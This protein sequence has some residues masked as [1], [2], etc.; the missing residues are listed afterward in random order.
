MA[1]SK[2]R[3]GVKWENVCLGI[4]KISKKIKKSTSAGLIFSTLPT[5]NLSELEFLYV[6]ENNFK[7]L[8]IGTYIGYFNCY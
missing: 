1:H 5:F 3:G 7:K 6:C 8:F 4:G 2:G